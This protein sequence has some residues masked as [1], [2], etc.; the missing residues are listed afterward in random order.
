MHNTSKNTKGALIKPSNFARQ[1]CKYRTVRRM[2]EKKK[3]NNEI[4]L[5]TSCHNIQSSRRQ[6]SFVHF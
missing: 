5:V 2:G 6:T 4:L 3:D 1:K